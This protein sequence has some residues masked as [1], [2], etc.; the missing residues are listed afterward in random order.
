MD[1][2]SP[3]GPTSV[4]AHLSTVENVPAAPIEVT[5]MSQEQ[6]TDENEPD[7]LEYIKS[8]MPP[9]KMKPKWQRIILSVIIVIGVIIAGYFGYS[10]IVQG[11]KETTKTAVK[12]THLL[13]PGT[14][15]NAMSQYISNGSDLNLSF[16]YPSNW[17]VT[18]KSN[19]NASDQTITLTSPI[20]TIVD[21]VGQTVSGK[22]VVMIRPATAPMSE[23]SGGQATVA[24][25]STQFAYTKPT[26]SQFQYPYLTYL[27]L[28]GGSNASAAFQEVV[29]TG[30]TSYSQGESITSST[31]SVDPIITASFT[32]C[33]TSAC[34]GTVVPLSVT[35]QTWQSGS[36]FLQTMSLFASL[37]LN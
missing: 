10:Q 7:R 22:I 34:G 26:S 20:Q 19:D 16:K 33:A 31:L 25:A 35:N 11:H 6:V 36:V 17:S 2:F 37:S 29:I 18:P 32:S 14:I 30:N 15:T 12:R 27:N 28:L 13:T 21:S 9:K 4:S 3:F 8:V 24:Q 1:R 23:L 5:P